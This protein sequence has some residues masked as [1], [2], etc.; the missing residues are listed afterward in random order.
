VQIELFCQQ[1]SDRFV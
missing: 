1:T